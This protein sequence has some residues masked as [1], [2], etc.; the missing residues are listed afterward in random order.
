M[1]ETAVPNTEWPKAAEATPGHRRSPREVWMAMTAV[2]AI[3]LAVGTIIAVRTPAYEAADEPGH[4][5]NIETL[6]SGHWYGMNAPC[7]LDRRIG[8]LQCSG[9][10]ANQAPLYYLL[11]AG[12]QKITGQPV[13]PQFNRGP[14]VQV[15]P[16]FFRGTSGLF[17][18]HS[19]A[20]HRFLLWLRLPNVVLGALTVL[21][22]FLAVRLITADPWTPVVAASFVAF[23]PRMLFLTS[24]VTNDNLVD[25]LG[26]VL[27]FLALRYV[28]APSGKRMAAVGVVYGLLVLTKL[29]TLP[30]ALVIVALALLAHGWKRRIEYFG[31]GAVAS[32]IVCGWYLVQNT[33]RYGDPLAR[34]T[35]AHYLSLLGALGSPIGKPYIVSD[36]VKTIVVQVPQRIVE[37]FWYVSDW[38][39]FHWSWPVDLVFTVVLAICLVG[40]VGQRPKR[41]AVTLAVI[42]A[43][44]MLSVWVVAFQ[45]YYQAKYGFVGL[46][47][48]AG[49]VALG[50]EKWK[51]PTRSS[52]RPCSWSVPWWRSRPTYWPFTGAEPHHRGG[53]SGSETSSPP[54]TPA[55]PAPP[56]DP[57]EQIGE[58]NA[59]G[60]E[61]H[62]ADHAG[63]RP[64]DEGFGQSERSLDQKVG[65]DRQAQGDQHQG[66]VLGHRRCAHRSV[67]MFGGDHQYRQ[68]PEIPGIRPTTEPAEGQRAEQGFGPPFG[69]RRPAGDDQCC[70]DD[71]KG[72][73]IAGIRHT[74]DG[75]GGHGDSDHPDPRDNGGRHHRE[76]L[77]VGR[78]QGQETAD[79]ELP[80]PG[81][82]RIVGGELPGFG[83]DDRVDER[84]RHHATE[85]D[86]EPPADRPTGGNGTDGHDE[87][88]ID[89]I[90]LL[91]HRQ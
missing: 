87:Q 11:F 80:S 66:E 79:G 70:T 53:S 84:D 69:S 85:G 45:T 13:Q 34:R 65:D 12:W 26:A 15:D 86:G 64:L 16:A 3:F 82:S 52:C 71:G 47:A 22:T 27:T 48:I 56:G 46:A 33:V 29:T 17:L 68:V 4:V 18:H 58:G 37:T 8:L 42:A 10:E 23:L 19:A 90:E 55:W 91:L 83:G 35:S 40:L 77:A 38:N 6:A 74:V 49:L 28:L 43:A 36:P 60:D 54:A 1:V 14:D 88:R 67:V 63:P 25:L 59:R 7:R 50:V 72:N 30:M 2:L 32:V 75:G 44:A 76:I 62:P 20:T 81:G 21:I 57:S 39:R 73:H 89:D 78:A 9:D 24:F 31:I 51:V 61:Q 41:R 5:Q